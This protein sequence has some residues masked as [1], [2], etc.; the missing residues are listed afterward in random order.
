MM[1]T[2]THTTS[3]HAQHWKRNPRASA[4]SPQSTNRNETGEVCGRG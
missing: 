1:L 3:I 2:L 4:G